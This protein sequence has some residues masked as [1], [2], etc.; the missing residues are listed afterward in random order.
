MQIFFATSNCRNRP[1]RTMLSKQSRR[2]LLLLCLSHYFI[3]FLQ[4]Y[5][6]ENI[7]YF[8]EV[9]RWLCFGGIP[10]RGYS[11][12]LSLS[13]NSPLS[14]CLHK[15]IFLNTK[16]EIISGETKTEFMWSSLRLSL[17]IFVNTAPGSVFHISFLSQ[18]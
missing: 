10:K 6:T 13:L 11:Q 1:F 9:E 5:L 2:L 8:F 12:E 4:E 16:F 18:C 14:L 7:H 3:V 17:R 15:F